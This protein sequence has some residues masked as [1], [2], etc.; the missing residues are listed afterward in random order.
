MVARAS[1]DVAGADPAV[2]VAAGVGDA[3]DDVADFGDD[4]LSLVFV[5]DEEA[6]FLAAADAADSLV[7][8]DAVGVVD[9]V[10]GDGGFR[11][12]LVGSCGLEVYPILARSGL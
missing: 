6:G 12:H 4:G 10:L 11:G 3:G 8:D 1:A 7:A 5:G 9:H 2:V